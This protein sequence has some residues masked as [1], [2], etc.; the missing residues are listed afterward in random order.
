MTHAV[1]IPALDG[2]SPLGFLA[3]LGLLNLLT[4]TTAEPAGLS[5]S[6]SNGTAVVHS[7]MS[8]LDEVTQELA[9]I[10]AAAADDAAITG[11][12]PGFP[13][14]AGVHADP[15]RR[16]RG[17]Y[18]ELAA[19]IRHID[20]RAAGYWLP[21]LLTDL[22]V[23]NNGRAGLTPYTAPSGKQNL[24]TF[25][26]KPL[27]CRPRQSEP[28]TRGASR[29]AASRGIHRRV[30][31]PSRPQLGRRRPTGPHGSGKRR[32]RS[33]LAGNHGPSD[34]AHH[35]RR[36]KHSRHPLAPHGTAVRHD[37]AT[38]APATRPARGPGANR[39]PMPDTR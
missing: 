6:P 2:R 34:A 26:S 25:F 10:A 37:L 15:M 32:T 28:D 33:H 39:A 14:R 19:E 24:R 3:A 5:F 8:S 38:V 9:A 20:A 11:V 18:R 30:P 1:D 13:L 31:R 23:D 35:R 4:D 17:S 7:S 16:P 12:D 36:R 27:A 22:A 29:L 21:H